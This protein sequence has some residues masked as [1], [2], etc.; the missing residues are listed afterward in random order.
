MTGCL[1]TWNGSVCLGSTQVLL[2]HIFICHRLKQTWSLTVWNKEIVTAW[3]KHRLS[4]TKNKKQ[5][6]NNHWDCDWLKHKLL[7]ASWNTDCDWLK[8]KLLLAG[9][10]TD[11]DWLEQRLLLAVWNTECY[12][13]AETQIATSWLKHRLWLTEVQIV[14]G[15][16]KHRLW[17]T[18]VKRLSL[19]EIEQEIRSLVRTQTVTDQ[20]TEIVID[21]NTEIVTEWLKHGLSLTVSNLTDSLSGPN[22]ETVTDQKKKKKKEKKRYCH[23]LSETETHIL[24]ET[25]WPENRAC[26][27]LADTQRLS[28]IKTKICHSQ[29]EIQTLSPTERYCHWL[30]EIL[31]TESSDQEVTRSK[32]KNVQ[33]HQ[34]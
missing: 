19:S 13:L 11:C 8:H 24:A 1:L 30:K 14:T 28:M 16:L 23:H 22:T 4:L 20:D 17:L 32:R 25:H 3:P 15:W 27:W 12:F 9:W 5:N 7:L 18:E 2:C 21:W 31:K 33:L 10:N 29:T 34:I 6:N 26:H